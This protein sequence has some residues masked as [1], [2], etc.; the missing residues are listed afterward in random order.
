VVVGVLGRPRA[1]PGRA[2]MLLAPRWPSIAARNAAPST[3]TAR[4]SRWRGPRSSTTPSRSASRRGA[5][6]AR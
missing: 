4:P 1:A 5:L 3:R 6:R 2:R